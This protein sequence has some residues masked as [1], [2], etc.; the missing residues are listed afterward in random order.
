MTQPTEAEIQDSIDHLKCHGRNGNFLLMTLALIPSF[1]IVYLYLL[2]RPPLLFENH[3]FHEIAI[4][5][6]ILQGACISFVSWLCYR[7]SGEPFLRWLTLGFLGFTLIYAPHGIFTAYAHHNLWLFLLYGPASR[8]VTDG[9]FVAALLVYGSSAHEEQR[10]NRKLYWWGAIGIFLLVDLAVAAIATSPV[11]GNPAVRFSMEIGALCL[12]TL[13]IVILVVRRIR[14]PLMTI[15]GFSLACFAQSS[16]A[17]LLARAWNHLWWLAHGIF[18]TG[19]LLLSY[20][21]IQVFLTTR[22]F[23]SEQFLAARGRGEAAG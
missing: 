15:Y 11:A 6:S 19:F 21:V 23:E 9:C 10:R 3:R 14:S 16:L 12:S 17:F 8:L 5:V 20:R 22:S 4:G 2:Q 7:S 18:A 13:A 1:A